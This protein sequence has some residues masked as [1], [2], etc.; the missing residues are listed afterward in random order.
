[1]DSMTVTLSLRE[2]LLTLLTLAAIVGLFYFIFTLRRL[3]TMVEE[4]RRVTARAEMLMSQ[5]QKVMENADLT[6]SSARRLIE[7]GQSSVDDIAAVSGSAR[8]L[9]EEIIGNISLVLSPIRYVTSLVHNLQ[10]AVEAIVERK[11][12]KVSGTE[13]NN[14][15]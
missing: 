10:R 14:E 4:W 1:V 3:V 15:R 6:L 2:V 5:L 8:R 11:R 13:E 9:S 7:S 12:K